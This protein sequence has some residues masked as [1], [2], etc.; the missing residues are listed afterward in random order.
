MKHC[1]RRFMLLDGEPVQRI[2]PV[3]ESRFHLVEH[4]LRQRSEAQDEF[5]RLIAQEA[6]TSFDLE[7]GPLIRGRLI[8]LACAGGGCVR[9][10]RL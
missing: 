9:S 10:A 7:A 2:I 3:E 4:D 6:H 5:D 1:A 8:W